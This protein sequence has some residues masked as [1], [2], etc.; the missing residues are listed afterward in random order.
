MIWKLLCSV[1]PLFAPTAAPLSDCNSR[2]FMPAVQK[3]AW[4]IKTQDRVVRVHWIYN[5]VNSVCHVSMAANAIHHPKLV[6]GF[7]SA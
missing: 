5:A 6:T 4:E 1:Q 7:W 2:D 3:K